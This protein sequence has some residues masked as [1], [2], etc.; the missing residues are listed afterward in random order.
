MSSIIITLLFSDNF[1]DKCEP[2]KPNP[3]VTKYVTA[4]I[5]SKDNFLIYNKNF[6]N[7]M[8]SSIVL[9]LYLFF[10]WIHF[11]A[12]KSKSKSYRGFRCASI[13]IYFF[14]IYSN[15]ANLNFRYICMII[16]SK[17]LQQEHYYLWQLF[18][19][20]PNLNLI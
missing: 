1:L 5:Y 11:N 8:Y 6:A 4:K 2:M 7:L 13:G 19:D 9:L 16:L 12:F 14:S 18:Q 17:D 10:I 20:V 3:P 15:L